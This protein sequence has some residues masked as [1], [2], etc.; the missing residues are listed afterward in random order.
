MTDLI[1]QCAFVIPE[2]SAGDWK[3]NGDFRH[4]R[5]LQ[6]LVPVVYTFP[7]MSWPDFVVSIYLC[8]ENAAIYVG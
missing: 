2:V 3:P 5:A 8:M 4:P 1:K 6:G 7:V